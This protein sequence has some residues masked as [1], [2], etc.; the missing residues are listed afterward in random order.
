[1]PGKVILRVEEGQ[2]AGTRHLFDE[3]TTCLMGRGRDCQIRL[4]NDEAHRVI[5]RMH[6]LL[7]INPPDIRIRDFGS[8]NGTEVNGERIGRRE[9]DQSIEEARQ[10]TFPEVDLSHGDSILL[11]DTTFHVEIVEPVYC[12]ECEREVDPEQIDEFRESDGSI[13][14]GDCRTLYSPTRIESAED[15]PQRRCVNCNCDVSHEVL[16]NRRGEYVCRK[17]QD[18]P[19]AL[20]RHL[21]KKAETG[22]HDLAAIKGYQLVK[23]LGRGGM[24]AV[25]LARNEDAGDEVALKVMLPKVA[26][27]EA[28]RMRFEREISVTKALRHPN[29][30]ELKDCGCSGG[31][32]YFT[33]EF[34]TAGSVDQLMK[35]H[36]GVLPVD[37]AVSIACQA[38]EGLEYAHHAQIEAPLNDGTT[39]TVHGVVHR[40]LSPHNIFLSNDGQSQIAKVGDFGL[41]KAFDTAGLSGYTFTGTTAGKP[42]FMPRQQVIDFKFAKPEVDVWAMAASLY[43]MLTGK[44]PRNYEAS[45]DPWEITLKTA[46]TPISHYQKDMP[47]KLAAVI[48]AALVDNPEI[49]VKSAAEFREQLLRATS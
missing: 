38:L 7:D 26:A 16:S 4:P 22:Q 6:C 1:M 24:G 30:V 13:V 18:D 9:R 35:Q 15:Q 37:L 12:R 33:L 5:S 34:C 46:A 8:L 43:N 10:Q 28:S 40:D 19:Q 14:C 11:G 47:R 27:D 44:F 23:Q 36:G 25:Y 21:L 41:A 48:D 42:S 45:G 3:R 17:C 31:T 29:V 39:R 49:P 2:L 20:L 32:F